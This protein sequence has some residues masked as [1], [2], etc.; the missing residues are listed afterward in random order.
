M[1]E[2][3]LYPLRRHQRRV[4]RPGRVRDVCRA[5]MWSTNAGPTRQNGVHRLTHSD[6]WAV[7]PQ[8]RA[9]ACGEHR[10]Y[11]FRLRRPR[12]VRRR[13]H[14]ADLGGGSRE[15]GEW[16]LV[17]RAPVCRL[18]FGSRAVRLPFLQKRPVDVP[19][20]R[21]PAQ[22]APLA[23]FGILSG[24][25]RRGGLFGQQRVSRRPKLRLGVR[26]LAVERRQ[27][28]LLVGRPLFDSP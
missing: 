26:Q 1:N 22:F 17:R 4:E 3:G 18:R 6:G 2:A 21:P 13:R 7:D 16:N 12:R 24:R 20:I 27:P 19:E 10:L 23:C 15:H 9:R 11:R 8:E 5:S 25:S 14:R 28:P